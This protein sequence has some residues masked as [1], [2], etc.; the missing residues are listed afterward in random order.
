MYFP[1]KLKEI[2]ISIRT[3]KLYIWVN[4]QEYSVSYCPLSE[5]YSRR[6]Y[7]LSRSHHCNG[8]CTYNNEQ[9]IH[10]TDFSLLPD[11]NKTF[12]F[13]QTT[14]A[15]QPL[16]FTKCFRETTTRISFLK[17]NKTC[18]SIQRWINPKVALL[19]CHLSVASLH[20]FCA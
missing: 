4:F 10:K 7:R 3:K 14:T 16:H 1:A 17:L 13:K 5:E 11:W 8:W 2:S 15:K 20:P 18:I 9:L 19:F 6:D 12:V